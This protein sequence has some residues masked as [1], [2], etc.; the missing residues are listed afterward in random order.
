MAYPVDN[1][2][3]VK[4]LFGLQQSMIVAALSKQHYVAIGFLFWRTSIW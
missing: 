1:S 2:G 3:S 4:C